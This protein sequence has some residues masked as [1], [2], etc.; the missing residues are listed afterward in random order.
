MLSPEM[1]NDFRCYGGDAQ[2][3]LGIVSA[4]LPTIEAMT[5]TVS[6]AGIGGEYEQPITGHTTSMTATI[7]F[8]AV[9]P[10]VLSILRPVDQTITLMAAIQH[11]TPA[12]PALAPSPIA[13]AATTKQLKVLMRCKPKSLPL[14]SLTAGEMM[15]TSI[16][17][18]VTAITITIDGVPHVMIDK[19]NSVYMI[20]G[21]D[22]MTKIR[23]DV[24][25]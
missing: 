1:V 10:Q 22:Y 13:G 20:D 12:L 5:Q 25:L 19:I 18:E 15:D 16:E 9:T 17:F 4:E 23:V 3:L 24:G 14:G 21:V 6:G 8:R 2:T 11:T 7:T